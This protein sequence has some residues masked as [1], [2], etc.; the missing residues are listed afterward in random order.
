MSNKSRLLMDNL[1][2]LNVLVDVVETGSF[3]LSAERL[4]LSRSAV[5]KCIARLEARLQVRLLIVQHVVF[6]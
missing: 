1:T 6:V 2:D 5:G 3:T 4:Q